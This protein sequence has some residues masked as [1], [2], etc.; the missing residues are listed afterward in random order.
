MNNSSNNNA[1]FVE[2]A[3]DYRE[4]IEACR[5]Q[6]FAVLDDYTK[7]YVYHNKNPEVNEFEN[8]Y[9][10]N[11][12]QIQSLSKEVI[13]ITKE[14]QKLIGKLN[15]DMEKSD[16]QLENE[17]KIYKKLVKLM[18]N[19]ENTKN[20]SEMLINDSKEQY[21]KIH[22][23]TWELFWGIIIVSSFLFKVFNQPTV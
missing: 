15:L 19:L 3:L 1:T 22:A 23:L 17:K 8:Y 6:F 18:A 21:N 11:K 14:I 12:N 5:S 7:Y 20:G 4:K 16:K 2:E 10:T 9:S 13:D